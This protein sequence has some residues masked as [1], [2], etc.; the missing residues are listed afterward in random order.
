LNR[1]AK[2]LLGFDENRVQNIH[3]PVPG[4]IKGSGRNIDPTANSRLRD[5]Q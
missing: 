3:S 4:G 5:L 1:E 2:A